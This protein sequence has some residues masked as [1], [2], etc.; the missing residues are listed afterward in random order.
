M[1]RLFFVSLLIHRAEQRHASHD[2][3]A[4]GILGSQRERG[5]EVQSRA[6]LDPVRRRLVHT[7]GH[8]VLLQDARHLQ[9]REGRVQL[10]RVRVHQLVLLPVPPA[11]LQEQP[12]HVHTLGHAI[13]E[14]LHV[15]RRVRHLRRHNHVVQRPLILGVLPVHLLLHRGEETLW[16]EE[17]REP[18]RLGPALPQPLIQLL[19]PHEQALEPRADRRAL[20]R[21]L[22]PRRG[23]GGV[24]ELVQRVH[25][26]TRERQR[27]RDCELKILESLGGEDYDDVQPVNLLPEVNGQ[28]LGGPAGE[29]LQHLLGNLRHERLG[30]LGEEVRA[31]G[32]DV[33]RFE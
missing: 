13:L 10:F 26:V 14:L 2:P 1:T 18:V 23:D 12:V 17:T 24:E 16:V 15:L 8:L 11:T 31:D 21:L 3:L 4:R 27:S 5:D 7:L 22:E 28:G 30:N 9:H 33:P 6:F 20:P 32:V 25:Q 19:V 29:L